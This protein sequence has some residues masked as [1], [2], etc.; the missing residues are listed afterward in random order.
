MRRRLLL[1]IGLAGAA[2]PLLAREPRR[3]VPGGP[4]RC[5][6]DL[7]LMDSGL[8]RALRDGFGRDTGIPVHL[9]PGPALPLLAA[10]AAGELDLALSNAPD[11]EADLERQG[12]VHDRRSIALGQFVLVG[13]KAAKGGADVTVPDAGI[14][15]AL[16]ALAA[17]TRDRPDA[18]VFVSANDGSGTHVAEQA[19]WRLAGVAPQA[20]WYRPAGSDRPLAEVVQAQRAWAIVERG[21]WVAQGAAPARIR[22]E[23]DPALAEPV[24]ALRSFRSPHP[25]A[26]FFSEWI[27]GR[28]GRAVVSRQ[29]AYRVPGA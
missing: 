12:L 25:A 26:R 17:A 4:L 15:V 7:A 22:L 18:L 5:G 28:R 21:A 9:V 6:T 29:R 24:H 27:A 11:A 8:A 1:A 14:A 13:P 10:L 20:P 2:S 19:A 3:N 23:T 16:Q